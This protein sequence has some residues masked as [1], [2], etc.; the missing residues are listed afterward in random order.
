M[1][2]MGT[3]FRG[4]HENRQEPGELEHRNGHVLPEIE[5]EFRELVRRR[6]VGAESGTSLA[7]GQARERLMGR[8]LSIRDF[9]Q[10]ERGIEQALRNFT[11]REG[12]RNRLAAI[13]APEPIDKIGG[14]STLA[15][16][17]VSETMAREIEQTGRTAVEIAAEMMKEAQQLA[18][19]LRANGKKMRERLREFAMLAKK[20]SSAMRDIRAEVRSP[21]EGNLESV[22]LFPQLGWDK[23]DTPE[24]ETFRDGPAGRAMSLVRLHAELPEGCI[25]N[26]AP[27]PVERYEIDR[28]ESPVRAWRFNEKVHNIPA[29]KK[30]RIELL[31]AARV[32]WTADEWATSHDDETR[33]IGSGIH[34]IDLATQ[35]VPCGS[36]IR[37]TF[38]WR[39]T[40]RW[41]GMDFTVTVDA[42]EGNDTTVAVETPN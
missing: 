39:D 7:L 1:D 37:F 9:R 6:K 21:P 33:E 22:A 28:T 17:E 11:H 32:H 5:S 3:M 20:V 12:K 15:I 18:A 34:L 13:A 26:M 35:N 31:A 41:E 42:S 8:E 29:G 14:M 36:H 23:S 10:V 25:F 40:E 30:L 16:A 4:R 27:H 19:D 38:Y 24:R 2:A